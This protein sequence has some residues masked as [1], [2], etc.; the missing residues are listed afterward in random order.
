MFCVILGIGVSV[1]KKKLPLAMTD[2]G[3][4]LRL[5]QDFQSPWRL[6]YS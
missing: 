5:L 6:Q 3:N 1:A 2:G 4:L